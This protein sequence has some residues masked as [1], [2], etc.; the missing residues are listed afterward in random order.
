MLLQIAHLHA[1]RQLLAGVGGDE[2]VHA[3]ARPGV[4]DRRQTPRRAFTE[5][6]REI[7]DHQET[8]RLGNLARL[9]V[10]LRDRALKIIVLLRDE[11][12][13]EM[14]EPHVGFL[15]NRSANL[16]LGARDIA[17]LERDNP[18][19]VARGGELGLER[20]R[21][22]QLDL[23][24]LEAAV[25]DENLCR[26]VADLRVL[27]IELHEAPVANHRLLVAA[28]RAKRVRHVDHD[29]IVVGLQ[30]EGVLVAVDGARVVV[31]AVVLVAHHEP[32]VD[33]L[34]ILVDD[35][36]QRVEPFVGVL[37]VPR[38]L[39]R[40]RHQ[41]EELNLVL[42]IG[43]AVAVRRSR[44]DERPD[45]AERRKP[46]AR[47]RIDFDR[48]LRRR[49]RRRHAPLERQ[50]L[51]VEPIAERLPLRVDVLRLLR[52]LLQ[53]VELGPRRRDVFVAA[54]RERAEIAP[55]EMEARV[56]RL[57]VRSEAELALRAR[58][59]RH[60]A[61]PLE[62]IRRLD[63]DELQRGRQDVDAADGVR[64]AASG[65]RIVR[66]PNHQ[67][68]VHRRLIDEEAVRPLAVLAEALA[69]IAHHDDDRVAR[70]IM[71][72]EI[73]EQ[74][75]DLRV[76]ERDLAD[77]RP[78]GVARLERLRRRVRRVRV[79]EMDPAEEARCAGAIE[80][81]ERLVGDLVARPVDAAERQRLVLAQIEVVEI[82][83]EALVQPPPRIEHVG[84]DEGARREPAALEHPGERR[85]ARVEEEAAVVPDTVFGWKLARE[86]RRVGGQRPRGGKACVAHG[87]NHERCDHRA[88][89]RRARFGHADH[90]RGEDPEQPL[91][92]RQMRH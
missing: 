65:H 55:A 52:I 43:E 80:P 14:R 54:G 32:R 69:V 91:P 86:E 2:G 40:L 50:Q 83:V 59:E 31:T 62:T 42:W 11:R 18:E 36:L 22:P 76:D 3:A 37:L 28:E 21:V 1:L 75:A 87:E 6:H 63:P 72:V 82:G 88:H 53:V 35:A 89:T 61:R 38:R 33:H 13:I 7:R 71:I 29:E 49:R 15:L 56:D 20:Q 81:G 24:F 39:A 74:T 77:V 70:E 8:E 34:R 10:V 5:I 17:A 25:V 92:R 57:G 66:R 41:V 4:G 90:E 64:D 23:C 48:R 46:L 79:V 16:A 60:D 73:R 78:A 44:A 58:H 67:R 47:L 12:E 45:V 85:L 9:L 19:R 30:L 51:L 26:L 84:A 27:R 68:H